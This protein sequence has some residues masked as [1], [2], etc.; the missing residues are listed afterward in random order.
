M[1]KRNKMPEYQTASLV[2]QGYRQSITASLFPVACQNACSRVRAERE[3]VN[4]LLLCYGC[5]AAH[6]C[7]SCP[8]ANHKVNCLW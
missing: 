4:S 1:E 5:R 8:V 6:Q 2:Y 3:P 7:S